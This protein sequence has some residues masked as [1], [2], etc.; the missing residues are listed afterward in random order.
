MGLLVVNWL[1][2]VVAIILTT[3]VGGGGGGALSSV[4][5]LPGVVSA[6]GLFCSISGAFSPLP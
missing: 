1:R 5:A 2:E 4:S 6:R 3:I